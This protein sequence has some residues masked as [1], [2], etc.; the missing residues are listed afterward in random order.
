MIVCV[1]GNVSMIFVKSAWVEVLKTVKYAK[2]VQRLIQQL[3]FVPANTQIFTSLKMN[4]TVRHAM[5]LV[6]DAM[7]AISLIA[8]V[9]K[10]GTYQ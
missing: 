4:S 2:Q 1:L 6:M 7:I 10:Q 8:I 5:R 9:V 3:P